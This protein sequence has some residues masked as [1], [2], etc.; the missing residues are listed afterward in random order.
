MKE[1]D[2]HLMLLYKKQ[3]EDISDNAHCNLEYES[4]CGHMTGQTVNVDAE[5]FQKLNKTQQRFIYV[6][7]S[8]E[9]KKVL[10][11][12]SGLS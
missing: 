11:L 1:F 12:V 7:P 10:F 6:G 9:V 3:Y 2:G 4:H 5:I 8:W